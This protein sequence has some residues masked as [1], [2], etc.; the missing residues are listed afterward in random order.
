MAWR[1]SELFP[2]WYVYYGKLL[3]RWAVVPLVFLLLF[4]KELQFQSPSNVTTEPRE[5]S[6]APRSQSQLRRGVEPASSRPIS[7][8]VSTQM[9]IFSSGMHANTCGRA[10]K[11][12]SRRAQNCIQKPTVEQAKRVYAVFSG[13]PL[14]LLRTLC[15]LRGSIISTV[16][17]FEHS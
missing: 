15:D 16:V 10:C 14:F 5:D 11:L 4:G 6:P 9:I 3:L 13:Y 17:T 2:C 1:F 7:A 8:A 12:H